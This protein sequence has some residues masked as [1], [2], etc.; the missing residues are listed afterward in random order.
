MLQKSRRLT[1]MLFLI[2]G[3]AATS[4]LSAQVRSIPVTTDEA[5][6]GQH[7]EDTQMMM[8]AKLVYS[9]HVLEGLV[10]HDFEA[11]EKAA[12]GLAKISLSPPPDLSKAGDRSDEQIYEHFRME[13]AR[14]AGQL[15]TQARR[16][17]LEA[18]AY[19]QQNLTATCIACH[20]YIRDDPQ[21]K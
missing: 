15:E 3:A 21:Q 6:R 4:I 10:T 18:T 13:F 7:S 9:Q 20:D 2:L 14:L 1:P 19:A 5:R 12:Q 8:Q 17:E 11:V 16:K